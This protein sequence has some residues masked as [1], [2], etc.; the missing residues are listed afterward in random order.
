MP[1]IKDISF[2]EQLILTLVLLMMLNE[3]PEGLVF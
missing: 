3:Q 1:I 2:Q